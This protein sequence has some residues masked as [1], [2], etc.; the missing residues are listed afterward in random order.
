[1][2]TAG[3]E[4]PPALL[5]GGAVNTLSVARSLG[6]RGIPVD[7]VSPTN[8]EVVK[9]SRFV[10]RVVSLP[11]EQGHGAVVEWLRSGPRGAV[12]IPCSDD[13]VELL[14]SHRDQLVELGYRPMEGDDALL[15]A[16]LDKQRT[17]E[18][19]ARV[20]VA[21]PRTMPVQ[22]RSELETA[23][24]QLRLPCALKPRH[25]HEFARRFPGKGVVSTDASAL[26]AAYEQVAAAG[27]QVVLT[28]IVPGPDVYRS[29]YSCIDAEG[30]PLFAITKR[31]L[32]QHPIGFG[33]GTLHETSVDP[34]VAAEGVRFLTG[35]G[36]RGLG[37]VEFKEDERD[38]TLRLIEC[39]VRPT[40]ADALLRRA[41]FDVAHMIY[42]RALDQPWQPPAAYA[43]G[44]RQW[45][46]VDDVRALVGYRKA[47]H[48]G[49]RGWLRSVA[50]R[51]VLPVLALD[52][53]MPSVV[54]GITF[55][56]RAVR[57]VVGRRWRLRL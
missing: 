26:L 54:N 29:C 37:N 5:L 46:P 22:S 27:V 32:R 40:A 51:P 50:G 48:M 49:V 30:Q 57:Y 31:K 45:H 56:R 41:G 42:S 43:P 24:R 15:L 16:M 20:G 6:G 3:T 36:F 28:E 25:A 17:Y 1:M 11:R 35:I 2:A 52:D 44:V 4:R 23:L 55:A 34:D 12:V 33:N 14:A 10:R 8:P 39:N 7:V 53:P 9:A 21:V 18:L 13:G 38:G 19:A 47:G